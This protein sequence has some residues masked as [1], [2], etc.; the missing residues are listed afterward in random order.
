MKLSA[1]SGLYS[2]LPLVADADVAD[3][4]DVAD[5]V[6][7]AAD[8]ADAGADAAGEAVACLGVVAAPGADR[9]HQFDYD[10]RLRPGRAR[11]IRPFGFI[12]TDTDAKGGWISSRLGRQPRAD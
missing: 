2:N 11:S 7:A 8:A 5:A 10:R 1:P 12:T 3:A 4:G 6:G 9:Q